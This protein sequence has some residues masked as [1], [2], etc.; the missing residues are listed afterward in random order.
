LVS[1]I[2]GSFDITGLAGASVTFSVTLNNKFAYES[3]SN[4]ISF[5]PDPNPTRNYEK[6]IPTWEYII[7]FLA[8]P[9]IAAVIDI[10]VSTV[11]DLV[12]Q[13]ATNSV[14]ASGQN[15]LAQAGPAVVSWTGLEHFQITDMG[16]RQH[17]YLRGTYRPTVNLA[18]ASDALTAPA[19]LS[20]SA[21]P[22]APEESDAADAPD[23]ADES[24]VSA[25][26]DA[27]AASDASAGSDDSAAEEQ[28]S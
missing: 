13:A 9:I 25:S 16:L 27:S 3:Q 6:H 22:A 24:D 26:S 15:S 21:A 2:E 28:S 4:T 19:E 11:T 14:G 7:G 17:V 8:G 12:A 20:A 5:L 18:V 10:V 23:A 1:K